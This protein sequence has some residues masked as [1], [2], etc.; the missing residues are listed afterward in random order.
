M[1][2]S[3]H[4]A[5]IRIT[6]KRRPLMK[7]TACV[8]IAFLVAGC[9][10]GPEPRQSPN[11]PSI[12]TVTSFPPD[13]G[14][15]APRV[16]NE[17]TML[18]A[19]V[20]VQHVC[21]GVDPRFRFDSAH[22]QPADTTSLRVLAA[23]MTTGLLANRTLRLVGHAD[24][25]GSDPYNDKLALRRAEAVKG[26]LVRAGVSPDRLIPVTRGKADAQKSPDT[27]DRRVDFE[28]IE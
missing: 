24:V 9:A 7:T 26:F 14:R 16:E 1:Q 27:W 13:L 2:S 28:I 17:E 19:P 23:C 5:F 11:T 22:L 15:G 25:R 4:A 18:Y 3:S 20:E 12:T 6:P 10:A 8:G 21:A